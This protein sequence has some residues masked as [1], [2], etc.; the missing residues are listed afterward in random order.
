MV[1][2]SDSSPIIRAQVL[3]IGSA[4]PLETTSG[5]EAIQQPLRERYP[6]EIESTLEGID[7]SLSITNNCMQIQYTSAADVIIK[8]PIS[9]LTMCAAVRCVPTV[10]GTTGEKTAKFVPLNDPLARGENSMRPAIFAA[11]T[12][13]T[14]GQKVL[15]C[16][17]FVCSS[18]KEAANLVKC[19]SIAGN[20]FKRHAQQTSPKTPSSVV[21]RPTSYGSAQIDQVSDSGGNFN[22]LKESSLQ[23]ATAS[24]M[25]RP[26]VPNGTADDGCMR[27][28]PG[29]HVSQSVP[30]DPKFVE[31]VAKHGYFYCN[32][33]VEIKKYNIVT[34]GESENNENIGE[35]LA[36][37]PTEHNGSLI[38]TQP[39]NDP[40]SL[41]ARSLPVK[42]VAP[43]HFAP[44][45]PIYIRLP[46]HHFDGS[47][48]PSTQPTLYGPP[49]PMFGRRNFYLP[50]PPALR[51]QPFMFS[52][53]GEPSQMFP[54]PGYI[55]RFKQGA[56]D[57]SG[58]SSS[59]A[60][61]EYPR[62]KTRT[63][64]LN[65]ERA[66]PKNIRY[67]D[68]SS[69]DSIRIR[70]STAPTDYDDDTKRTE[71]VVR[72]EDKYEHRY[73]LPSRGLQQQ[74]YSRERS[75]DH[76]YSLHPPRQ[77]SYAPILTFNPNSMSRSLPP[78]ERPKSPKGKGK[79]KSKNAKKSTKNKSKFEY[80]PNSGYT[81]YLPQGD[82]ST[83]SQ[84]GY[85]SE[86]PT[87][88]DRSVPDPLAGY[89]FYPPRD[90]RRNSSR[91]VNE[92][93]FLKSF[94]E[95]TGPRDSKVY[96]TAY[97]R[98]MPANH[99]EDIWKDGEAE[100]TMY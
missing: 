61:F 15:E 12:R 23:S 54:P 74:Q 37:I 43:P 7:A 100:F 2:L 71:R 65:D 82:M 21:N 44:T 8:F 78:Q 94:V 40:V 45:Q 66:L 64:P 27:L 62:S 6:I 81:R 42:P 20:N 50:Q 22:M 48:L 70:P 88:R 38:G 57:G 17:G 24:I 9:S 51:H 34:V 68:T 84:I 5:I 28:I 1:V 58:S 92:N 46:K 90:F 30:T 77:G 53:A 69:D 52:R 19:A 41:K 55:R 95:E 4:V 14:Q 97:G 3:Y 98:N 26:S 89:Q 11:V 39:H 83:D 10:N 47:P 56:D 91:F 67:S 25:P 32:D 18:T 79:K 72:R 59:S 31:P 33:K 85:N 87:T 29:E 16:H 36:S 86:I 63:M 13:C 76:Y 35:P 99:H 93:N 80:L 96:S 73:P 60:E 49:P 75:F